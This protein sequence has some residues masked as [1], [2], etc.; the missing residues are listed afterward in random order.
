MG[1]EK[2]SILLGSMMQTY[3]QV[4]KPRPW[5]ARSLIR[6]NLN[7]QASDRGEFSELKGVSSQLKVVL[8]FKVL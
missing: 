3:R 8:C 4:V 7:K 1:P 5:N 6:D 2:F